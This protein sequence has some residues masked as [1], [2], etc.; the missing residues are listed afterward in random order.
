MLGLR[1]DPQHVKEIES[2]V[3]KGGI[4][5]K[6]FVWAV[7]LVVLQVPLVGFTLLAGTDLGRTQ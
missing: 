4:M 2:L 3:C 5:G 1:E 6:T 7:A